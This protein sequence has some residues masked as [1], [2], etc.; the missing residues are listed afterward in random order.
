MCVLNLRGMMSLAADR[1]SSGERYLGELFVEET[2]QRAI[3]ASTVSNGSPRLTQW[4]ERSV[5]DSS[6]GGLWKVCRAGRPDPEDPASLK[7]GKRGGE[8][9]RWTCDV[10]DAAIGDKGATSEGAEGGGADS[11]TSMCDSCCQT[12]FGGH[13]DGVKRQRK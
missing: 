7:P 3:A 8:V 13:D 2:S 5:A 12:K 11:C 4:T 1:R 9:S 6:P 10:L